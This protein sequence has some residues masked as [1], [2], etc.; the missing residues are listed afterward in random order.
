V[1]LCLREGQI[2]VSF[3]RGLYKADPGSAAHFLMGLSL[4]FGKPVARSK[5]IASA[6]RPRRGLASRSLACSPYAGGANKARGSISAAGQISRLNRLTID[7]ITVNDTVGLE[8]N[9]MPTAKQPISI[10]VAPSV[11]FDLSNDDIAQKRL[12][13]RPQQ[14]RG[15]ARQQRVQRQRPRRLPQRQPV[16]TGRPV[17]HSVRTPATGKTLADNTATWSLSSTAL[18]LPLVWTVNKQLFP[19]RLGRNGSLAGKDARRMQLHGGLGLFQ[20]GGSQGVVVQPVPQHRGG[21]AHHRLWRQ[22][23]GLQFG[24]RGIQC[25]AEPAADQLPGY[26][27]SSP[28]RLCSAGHEPAP[29]LQ[30]QPGIVGPARAHHHRR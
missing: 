14:C 23:C 22:F 19:P 4:R 27:T 20:A 18:F 1:T 16:L 15:Q 21:D 5:K 7:G 8:S 13:R 30:S 24:R 6:I 26:D 11:R 10:D 29:R 3:G 25:R 12:D 2:P 17:S 28:R 9:N